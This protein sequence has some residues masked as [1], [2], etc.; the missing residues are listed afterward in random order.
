MNGDK[1]SAL[2]DDCNKVADVLYNC[3]CRSVVCQACREKRHRRHE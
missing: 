2:C 1:I 3:Y